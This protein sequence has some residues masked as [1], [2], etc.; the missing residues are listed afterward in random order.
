[1][2]DENNMIGNLSTVVKFI[3]MSLAGWLLG[4]LASKGLSL[5]IDATVLSECIGTVIMFIIAWI[6]ATYFNSFSIFGN[7]KSTACD[8]SCE[9]EEDLI[10]PEYMD[11]GV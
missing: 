3:S 10:N 4:A 6:D 2:N 8:C 1:M 5:P 11:D 9:D 7:D